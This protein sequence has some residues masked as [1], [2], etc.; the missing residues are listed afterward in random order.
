MKRHALVGKEA[1]LTDFL[2]EC[3]TLAQQTIK[4]RT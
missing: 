2:A 4:E 1:L 3:D